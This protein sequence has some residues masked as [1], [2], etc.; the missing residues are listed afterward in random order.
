MLF[1]SASIHA[2]VD[3]TAN[4][5]DTHDVIDNIEKRLFSELGVRTTVHMD[6]IV[7]NDEETNRLKALVVAASTDIDPRLTIHDFRFV[8]GKSHSNLIFDIAAPFELKLTDN[9]I[10]MLVSSAVS[11]INPNYFTVITID[12]Q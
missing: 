11:R 4:V 8:K 12:R 10:K 6:P 1:R 9:E 5:F 3:G 7:T 2:E